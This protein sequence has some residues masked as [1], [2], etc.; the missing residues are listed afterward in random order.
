MAG[1]GRLM[2]PVPAADTR[3]VRAPLRDRMVAS[4]CG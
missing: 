2:G 4:T 1:R 3:V